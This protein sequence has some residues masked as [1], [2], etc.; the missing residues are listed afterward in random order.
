MSCGA[1]A[2]NRLLA[3]VVVSR[4]RS[5]LYARMYIVG[6][7]KLHGVPIHD[8]EGRR[9]GTVRMSLRQPRRALRVKCGACWKRAGLYRCSSK[10][11]DDGLH[12]SIQLVCDVALCAK[13]RHQGL[14]GHD[15]CP[16]HRHQ[17][18]QA[19]LL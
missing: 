3:L 4:N 14:D 9:V 2:L 19:R 11:E 8:D 5:D 12:F 18:V 17:A 13:C 16:N 15:F 1:C 6:H 7:R 10:L